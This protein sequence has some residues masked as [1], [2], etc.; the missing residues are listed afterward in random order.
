MTWL[1]NILHPNTKKQSTTSTS[2]NQGMSSAFSGNNSSSS[3]NW[4]HQWQSG[5]SSTAKAI[6]K[7]YNVPSHS[8]SSRRSSYSPPSGGTSSGSRTIDKIGSG[9]Y[10]VTT[11]TGTQYNFKTKGEASKFVKNYNSMQGLTQKAIQMANAQEN[12]RRRHLMELQEQRNLVEAHEEFLKHPLLKEKYIVVKKGKELEGKI[13]SAGILNLRYSKKEGLHLK[14]N[15]SQE[16]AGQGFFS[17]VSSIFLYPWEVYNKYTAQKYAEKKTPKAV[18]EIVGG[19]KLKGFDYTRQSGHS[20]QKLTEMPLFDIYEPSRNAFME[21]SHPPATKAQKEH[22]YAYTVGELGGA[23]AGMVLYGEAI[24][25]GTKQSY[26]VAQSL[27]ERNIAKHAS[28]SESVNTGKFGSY[29]KNYGTEGGEMGVSSGKA[30]SVYKLKYK[31]K[32]LGEYEGLGKLNSEINLHTMPGRENVGLGRS[33]SIGELNIMKVKGKTLLPKSEIY[34]ESNF[35]FQSEKYAPKQQMTYELS[36][37]LKSAWISEV[38]PTPKYYATTPIENYEAV[39]TKEMPHMKDIYNIKVGGKTRGLS[40][41][42]GKGGRIFENNFIGES[43]SKESGNAIESYGLKIKEFTTEDI[44]ISGKIKSGKASLTGIDIGKGR[45]WNVE[46]PNKGIKNG[47]FYEIP[48]YGNAKKTLLTPL[49]KGEMFNINL[50][51]GK[52]EPS[53]VGRE[54]SFGG[55][56]TITKTAT[57]EKTFSSFLPKINTAQKEQVVKTFARTISQNMFQEPKAQ[58]LGMPFLPSEKSG[59]KTTSK[60][61]TKAP[62]PKNK[63]IGYQYIGAPTSPAKTKQKS[64]IGIVPMLGGKSGTSTRSWSGYQPI[65]GQK[66]NPIT[67]VH[68]GVKPKTKTGQIPQTSPVTTPSNFVMPPF[69]GQTPM[70]K[71]PSFFFPKVPGLSFGTGIGGGKKG[72]GWAKSKGFTPSITAIS[73]GLSSPKQRTSGFFSGLG[74]RYMPTFGR[75]RKTTSKKKPKKKKKKKKR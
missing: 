75:K 53:A 27:A 37:N 69:P 63:P 62:T 44:G 68:R 39:V 47:G 52:V 19:I 55:G 30:T 4:L 40:F 70:P 26:K 38:S 41:P 67:I 1:D 17:G 16:A 74:I 5:A 72:K 59:K 56:N 24:K 35:I 57:S 45:F 29:V 12:E 65:T 3:S 43:L 58:I 73:L 54:F 6:K 51:G 2:S 23:A 66:T 14:K 34:S 20:T 49:S 15:T 48:T 8:Y 33:R 71:T 60:K 32:L 7:Q 28:I 31:S 42:G 18:K 61:P 50:G 11:P 25:V 21:M 64:N 9:N 46:L 22:P 13:F 36:P 10:Y